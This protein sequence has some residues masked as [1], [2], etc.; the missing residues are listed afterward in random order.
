MEHNKKGKKQLI[1]ERHPV[2]SR[3]VLIAWLLYGFFSTIS[4]VA[5]VGSYLMVFVA[6]VN[7]FATGK[8]FIP[9]FPLSNMDILI[10]ALFV[11]SF[12][13]CLVLHAIEQPITNLYNKYYF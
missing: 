5:L 2:V 3:F 1:R 9:D 7:Y 4:M 8:F 11:C 13:M 10:V 12:L 6:G